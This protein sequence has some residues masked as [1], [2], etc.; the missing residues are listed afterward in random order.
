MSGYALNMWIKEREQADED[1]KND[2]GR[3]KHH[4]LP[5]IGDMKLTD[6]RAPHVVDLFRAIRFPKDP[7]KKLAQ[8]TIYNIYAVTSALFRDAQ[9]KGLIEATPC[10]L[11]DRELGP[12]VD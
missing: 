4:V 2:L 5:V 1:W 11:S 8:R 3:L 7:E 10:V 9:L 6:V 12:L